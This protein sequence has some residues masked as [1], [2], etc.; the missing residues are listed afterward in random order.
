MPRPALRSRSM[1][2]VHVTTPGGKNKV[3]HK[4]R[5][6]SDAKCGSCGAVMKQV[7]TGRPPEMRNMSKTKKRPERPFGGVLCSKCMR[8]KIVEGARQ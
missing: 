8:K 1:R 6:A 4:P 3:I 7:A 2:R 5:K